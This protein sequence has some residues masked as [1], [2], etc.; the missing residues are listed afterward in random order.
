MLD[1]ATFLKGMALLAAAYP[2]YPCTKE[3]IQLYRAALNDFRAQD[4]QKVVMAHIRLQ[5]WFPK[6]CELREELVRLRG[7]QRPTAE[8]EWDRLQ[9]AAEAPEMGEAT[10][11]ALR[12][13]CGDWQGFTRL[14][15]HDLPFAYQRFRENYRAAMDQEDQ[16][17]RLGG[18]QKGQRQL[19]EVVGTA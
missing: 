17:L 15:Y 14:T 2:D 7:F 16:R 18:E 4:F 9:Q 3:T 1:E 8:S 12:A 10:Q 13:A 5:K 11:R 6:V 19:T